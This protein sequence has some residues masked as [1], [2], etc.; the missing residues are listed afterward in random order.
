MQLT[1]SRR[2]RRSTAPTD[3]ADTVEE[4]ARSARARVSSASSSIASCRAPALALA[5]RSCSRQVPHQ[6]RAA[7]HT[8]Q[9]AWAC[10]AP[11]CVHMGG[12]TTGVKRF[13]VWRQASPQAAVTSVVY[14]NVAKALESLNVRAADAGQ[15]A[16]LTAPR[17]KQVAGQ[18]HQKWQAKCSVLQH[19]S[20]TAT[21]AKDACLVS[22]AGDAQVGYVVLRCASDA[23]AVHARWLTPAAAL[24]NLEPNGRLLKQTRPCLTCVAPLRCT[25]RWLTA[26]V[27][28]ADSEQHRPLPHAS[29]AGL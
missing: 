17:A 28:A 25:M 8:E 11:L 24:P 21:S 13:L 16:G 7:P 22:L 23:P 9:R 29:G 1:R 6:K 12:A 4:G 20:P 5:V 19:A 10:N 15:R 2:K 14:N 26:A 27:H 18:S 3:E